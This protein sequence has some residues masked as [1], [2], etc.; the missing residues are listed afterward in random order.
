MQIDAGRILAFRV[1][2]QGLAV[3]DEDA[4]GPLRG[5]A[6]QDSPPGAAAAALAARADGLAAGDVERAIHD[7][8]TA[9]ALY[10]PRTATAVVPAAEAPAFATAFLPGD[11]AGLKA[12][13]AQAV[14]ERSE[15]YAEPVELAVDAVADALD[16]TV[17]SRDD[18]HAALRARLPAELLPWCNGCRSHHARRGL[19]VMASLRGRLCVAGRAGRQPA[20]ARTDQWTGWDPPG[21][22]AAGAELVRRY[23]TAYG[24][25]THG[26]FAQWA[27]LGTA[28]GRAL[29]ALL[30]DELVEVR[31]DGGPR[32]WALARDVGR[33]E[34][35][36]PAQGVRL[37]APGDPLLLGRDREAL[38]PDPAVRGEVWRPIGGAGVVLSD[39]IPAGLWRARKQGRRLAVEL[40]AFGAVDRAALRDEL[41]RL[42]PHRGC[43]TVEV[44]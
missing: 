16:G 27:G 7:E 39:G 36:P 42:A 18:L 2:G 13:V 11:D 12:I 21:P 37:V 40:E 35:P 29:W 8:R 3:R 17:L 33:L 28:H 43:A 23:L 26:H 5:W 24:P 41:E 22:D 30:S 25:S 1:A 38:L 6:V 44:A 32:A 34:D 10:N 31:A 15:G 19:L 14:P 20:F 4:L 9:V